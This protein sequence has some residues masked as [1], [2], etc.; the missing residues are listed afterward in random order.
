MGSISSLKLTSR[1]G[2]VMLFHSNV[3]PESAETL[4]FETVVVVLYWGL[5]IDFGEFTTCSCEVVV[6]VFNCVELIT[7]A[8]LTEVLDDGLLVDSIS[9]SFQTHNGRK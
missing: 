2:S 3:I 1:T 5:E 8:V 6:L 9:V 7:L 4:P